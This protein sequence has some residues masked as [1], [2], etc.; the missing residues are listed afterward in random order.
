MQISFNSI[1]VVRLGFVNCQFVAFLFVKFSANSIKMH[2]SISFFY[3][4][5]ILVKIEPCN[6]LVQFYYR[7]E[8]G[9]F[10]QAEYSEQP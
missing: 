3:V 9:K 7:L 6:F 4:V 8:M 1:F 5:A 2:E 10:D